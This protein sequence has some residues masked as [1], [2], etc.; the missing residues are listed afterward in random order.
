MSKPQLIDYIIISTEDLIRCKLINLKIMNKHNDVKKNGWAKKL[1]IL[2]LSIFCIQLVSFAKDKPNS[3][4]E[5]VQI[6]TITY[7]YRS[8]PDQSLPAILEY[9]VQS[10]I[11]SVELMGEP[12]EEYAGIPK[13]RIVRY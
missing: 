13:S 6:G 7:S 9:I 8:M 1:T 11:N 3:K 12:V 4:F 10:G 5:G 2:F